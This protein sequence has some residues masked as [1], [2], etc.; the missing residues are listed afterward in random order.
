MAP[1]TQVTKRSSASIAALA[2]RHG[3]HDRNSRHRTTPRVP[4]EAARTLESSVG[5]EVRRLRKSLELTVTE[6]GVAAGISAGMLSK[7]ENGNISPSLGT[8]H[9][10]AKALDVPI[11]WLFAQTA[12]PRD[13]SFVKLGN[14]TRINQ[15]SAKSGHTCDVLGHSR[16]DAI[17]VESYLIT[18]AEEAVPDARVRRAGVE[19]V[20]MLSGKARYRNG[21]RTYLLG[22][23]DAL[24]FD[25][26]G[27]HGPEDLFETPMQYLS[28][29]IYPR[30]A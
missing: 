14:G 25:A 7:I 15:R 5:F 3:E 17:V 18:P 27:R 30:E 23:G 8:L 2:K 1:G 16:A 26:A 6:L 9:A 11:G 29:I 28:I 19:F 21:E 12:E 22:P 13:C 24:F 4:S 20:L 10:V